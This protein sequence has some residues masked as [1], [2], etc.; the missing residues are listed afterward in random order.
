MRERGA[1]DAE[2]RFVVE[3]PRVVAAALDAGVPLEAC[4]LGP[5]AG[6]VE[7]G[8]VERAV[9]GGAT[10]R[11]I[12]RPL[13][14]TVTPQPILAVAP[15]RRRG[16]DA[17]AD[18]D[19]T[20]VAPVLS[21]PG[22]VGTLLRSAAAAGVRAI[23][24]GPGSVD[25]YNPKVVRASAGACFAVRIVEGVPAVQ[26]L[27]NLGERG[28]RR[29]AA[30]ARGGV[31]P[32]ECDLAAPTAFVLGHETRGV[33]DDLPVDGTTTLPMAAGESLNAGVAGSILLFEAARQRRGA[34]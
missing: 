7:R 32:E 16:L 21:D 2:G 11:V 15:F 26:V 13:G 25:A 34:R 24:L 28:L 20:I 19:L 5:G 6:S 31:P 1:R 12:D 17:M 8:L 10:V 27:E 33:G 23:S 3:G 4:F 14:D 9:T 30:V 18:V 29:L 22:N